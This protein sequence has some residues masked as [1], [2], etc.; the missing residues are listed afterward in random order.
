MAFGLQRRMAYSSEIQAFLSGYVAEVSSHWAS[1]ATASD[2]EVNFDQ[3]WPRVELACFFDWIGHRGA[4][5]GE[6]HGSAWTEPELDVL[7]QSYRGMLLAELAGESYVKRRFNDEVQQA[8][9][10]SRAAIE[11]KFCNLSAVLIDLGR[12]HVPGYKPRHHYQR[13]MLEFVRSRLDSFP[14]LDDWQFP[15]APSEGVSR[16]ETYQAELATEHRAVP[17]PPGTAEIGDENSSGRGPLKPGIDRFETDVD[18]LEKLAALWN[19]ATGGQDVADRPSD[20]GI[21]QTT[22]TESSLDALIAPRPA[23]VTEACSWFTEN[24]NGSELP[25]FLFLVGGPGAGKSHA[26]KEL[27][28]DFERISPDD[29][30]LAHRTYHYD[31]PERQVVLINDATIP[32]DEYKTAPLAKEVRDCLLGDQH[33]VAC[34]N[35]GILVEESRDLSS[36]LE[37]LPHAQILIEWLQGRGRTL[38]ISNEWAIEEHSRTDYLVSGWLTRRGKRIAAVTAVFVDVCSLLERA[39]SVARDAEGNLEP[40]AYVIGNFKSRLNWSDDETSAG[41]LLVKILKSL[42][43]PGLDRY[44]VGVNPI[45]ANIRSL[46]SGK[47]RSGLLANLRAAEIAKGQRFSYR[48]IWGALVRA[49]VG[50]LPERGTPQVLEPY[51]EPYSLAYQTDGNREFTSLMSLSRIRI[52]QA[53]FG[54]TDAD[55]SG[56]FDLRSN[57]ITRLT[58]VV[59]PMRDARP[60]TYDSNPTDGWASI[61]TEAFA[62]TDIDESPLRVIADEAQLKGD[63]VI[64]ESLTEFDWEMDEAYRRAMSSLSTTESERQR[65]VHWYGAYLG[66]LYALVHGIPAFRPEI[67]N[68]TQASNLSPHIPNELESGLRALL[69]PKRAPND[70]NSA[71]LIPILDSRTNPIVGTVDQPKI[72]LQTG[73]F[74]MRVDSI[75]ES[76]FLVLTEDSTEVARMPLDLPL[77]R[78]ARACALEHPGVTELTEITSPRLERFRAARLVPDQL[79]VDHYKIVHG[80]AASVLVVKPAQGSSSHA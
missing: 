27:V 79:S 13:D 73:N 3:S 80:D 44:P 20:T 65:F 61:V 9:N 71:S 59:D 42:D 62:G 6:L 78:E 34:V 47:V 67:I 7:L 35:R 66:R 26:T 72:A 51:F 11:F 19:K 54:A 63:P 53:I 52:S 4:N 17:Q 50:D 2:V 45:L 43:T 12:V 25:K 29:D 48:E 58:S 16:Q 68:W 40:H 75:A 38:E 15:E 22:L 23:G 64:E 69:R 77:I 1:L 33:L 21:G 18:L 70:L 76:I 56:G 24:L 5:L 10:R 39:P 31:A 8:T 37:D 55:R 57:P 36:G 74:E 49:I 41:D 28:A 32:S 60:G 30:G 46:Q 14:V